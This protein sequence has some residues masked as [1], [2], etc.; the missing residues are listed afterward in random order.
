LLSILL[1]VINPLFITPFLIYLSLIIIGGLVIGKKLTEKLFMP[2]V[3]F[4]MHFSW[5]IGFLS[6]PRKLLKTN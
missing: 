3:L 2:L 5:G 6:S 1:S 4:V